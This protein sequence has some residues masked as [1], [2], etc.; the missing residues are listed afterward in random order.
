M[1]RVWLCAALALAACNPQP[2]HT[3]Q[4]TPSPSPTGVPALKI[5]GQGTSKHPITVTQTSGKRKLYQL[6]TH[7]YTS[8]S[9]QSIAQGTFQ[10]PTVTFYDK[11]GTKMTAKAPV[12]TL[13]GGK[14]VI[15]SGGVHATTSTGLNLTC[16]RLT[17]DQN[18]GMLHGE[19]HVRITGMQGGQQQMLTGNSFTSDVKL[20]QMVMK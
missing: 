3:L 15:L 8:R 11:D 4:A 2:Q 16:D 6:V 12:A 18:S 10:R 17:Y 13:Q 14:Q 20:T 5:T 19:G 9:A 1:K 7:S